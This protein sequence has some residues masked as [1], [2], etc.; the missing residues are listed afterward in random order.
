MS[1]PTRRSVV[2][3]AGAAGAAFGLSGPLEIIPSAFAQAA[4]NPLNPKGLAFFKH[5][6][7]GIEITT[8]FEGEQMAPIEASFISNASIEDMKGALKTAGFPDD[9][10]PNTYTVTFVTVGGRTIMFDSGFGSRDNPGVLQTAGR[11]A[12][13][14]KAAGIDLGKL[15]A[16]VV[17]HFHPD[18]IFGLFGKDNA[19][20]YENIEIVV[21]EAEYKYWADP[22]VI[23]KLAP[24]RQGIARRVQATMPNWKNLRQ[25]AADKDALPGIRAVATPGHTPGHTSFL[26]SDG[27]AQVM[28]LGDLTNIPP[29]NMKN[30]GWHIMFDQDAVLAEKTRREMFDR[31]VADKIV[32]TGY[33]WGMPGVGTVAKDGAGYA[34]VPVA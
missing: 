19:Q 33:H 25:I 30:P 23:D 10:R 1:K 4:A 5:K 24:S 32:C 26:V 14:A 31:V 29:I 13:N 22:A 27:S 6:V 28:V 3:A 11:L 15:S 34:L 7:G 16:V 2:L 20:V 8:V 18:H 21:P 12:E 17:T 9:A